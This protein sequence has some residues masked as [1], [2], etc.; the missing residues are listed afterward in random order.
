MRHYEPFTV[1]RTYRTKRAPGFIILKER[2]YK[3]FRTRDETLQWKCFH[4]P[5]S[6][7]FTFQSNLYVGYPMPLDPIS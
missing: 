4:S 7:F 3:L 5:Y 1:L 6:S 2:T